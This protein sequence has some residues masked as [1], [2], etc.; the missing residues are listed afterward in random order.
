VLL[1]IRHLLQQQLGFVA[2]VA[3]EFPKFIGIRGIIWLWLWLWLIGWHVWF[4]LCKHFKPSFYISFLK[5]NI[6]N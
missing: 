1:L 6:K 2:P 4:M 3:L 5:S